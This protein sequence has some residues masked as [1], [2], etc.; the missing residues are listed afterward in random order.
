MDLH[1]LPIGAT[2]YI[3][4][5]S[6]RDSIRRRLLDIGLTPG[7]KITCLYQ[8]PA[9]DPRAYLVLGAVIALRLEEAS[10]IEV[11]CPEPKEGCTWD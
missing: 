7:A 4:E 11:I 6:A 5:L 1:S 3:K 9:G 8:S 2:A 10:Q